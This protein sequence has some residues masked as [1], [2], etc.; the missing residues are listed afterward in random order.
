MGIDY[1]H[2]FHVPQWSVIITLHN[3]LRIMEMER[4]CQEAQWM[5]THTEFHIILQEVSQS[6]L[7]DMEY[8]QEGL[9][10]NQDL[11][12]VVIHKGANL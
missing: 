12:G 11:L 10:G 3:N 7:R 1:N 6:K 2:P 5:K 4:E 8:H 9:D